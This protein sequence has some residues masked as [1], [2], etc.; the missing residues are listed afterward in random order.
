MI[1]NID[2]K[3]IN[4]IRF[5]SDIFSSDFQDNSSEF[6]HL[7]DTEV[8]SKYFD[9]SLMNKAS[10]I[11]R[12]LHPEIRRIKE[13]LSSSISRKDLV[14]NSEDYYKEQLAHLEK[15]KD[16]LLKY[17]ERKD[18]LEG[19][20]KEEIA[21]H[22]KEIEEKEFELSVANEKIK[23]YQKELE[24][25]KKQ[26]NA[27]V[28]WNSKIK[29][30][31]KELTDCLRPINSEHKRLNKMFWIYTVSSVVVA[32]LIVAL[33]IFVFCKLKESTGFPDF[34][35]Y[36]AA[37]VP[38]PVFGGLLWAFIIQLNR[39]QRQLVILAKHIH[40]ITYIEGLL[41][42][43]NSLSSNINDSTKRVNIAIDRLLDNHLSKSSKA[44][45]IN[46]ESILK[47]EKKDVVPID[48]VIKLL[49]EAK[50]IIAN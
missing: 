12:R 2:N 13:V 19:K 17:I 47:E 14:Y 38:I 46:E 16:D 25:K 15:Q 18:S 34:E 26:E 1:Y 27:I 8:E 44:G 28:E 24:E 29:D 48:L 10:R 33:E 31:F 40:E 9:S 39:T 32:L 6:I 23:S 20:T 45:I 50:N 7:F 49:K 22:K 43:I 11:L 4:I 30:T 41:L 37:I 35:D 36:L 3:S 42:S 21:E 5:I